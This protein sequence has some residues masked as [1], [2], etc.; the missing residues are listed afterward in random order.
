MKR[1]N[2]QNFKGI[3]ALAVKFDP[4]LTVI[5][6]E[7]ASG[8]TSIIDAIAWVLTGKDS[9]GRSPGAKG[10]EIK[11]RATAEPGGLE[12]H[13]EIEWTGGLKIGRNYAEKWVK[14]RGCVD[15]EFQ[16]HEETRLWNGVAVGVR[17]F[18]AMLGDK[19]PGIQYLFPAAAFGRLEWRVQREVL[20]G[21]AGVEMDLDSLAD[22]LRGNNIDDARKSLKKSRTDAEKSLAVIPARI[23]E[24]S[25]QIAAINIDG[26]HDAIDAL[27]ARERELSEQARGVLPVAEINELSARHAELS[28]MQHAVD[29]E[30]WSAVRARDEVIRSISDEIRAATAQVNHAK[31]ATLDA[32]EKYMALHLRSGENACPTCG[33]DLPAD[34]VAAANESHAKRKAQAAEQFY[35]AKAEY[36]QAQA[37]LAEIQARPI[38]DEPSKTADYSSE[39]NELTRQR[40]ELTRPKQASPEMA[41][42]LAEIRQQI[43][44]HRQTLAQYTA[45]S[46]AQVR[47][48][49][50]HSEADDL[51]GIID[52]L[53]AQLQ[54][55]EDAERD[56]AERLAASVNERFSYCRWELF[57][58]QINGG[59]EACCECRNEAGSTYSGNMSHSERIRADVDIFNALAAHHGCAGIPVIIDDAESIAVLP[60][61]QHQMIITEV[62]S[63]KREATIT[64]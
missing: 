54:R 1:I 10:F 62:E 5:R 40:N 24:A 32:R 11:P 60:E 47:V 20:A 52:R 2:I 44:A 8:K 7:N 49:Q 4:K 39:M 19:F 37:T 13:V 63:D 53:T 9:E 25:R 43:A 28:A 15:Q 22:I 29:E 3:S 57:R 30:Y 64:L 6:G 51:R 17:E 12:V 41:T 23:D 26:V 38:P 58:Q 55:L 35:A 16:G 21:L 36:E 34:Q 46:Q 33:Q 14:K 45:A 59:I 50:L 31:A 18:D 27:T 42:E 56:F 61:T 48:A